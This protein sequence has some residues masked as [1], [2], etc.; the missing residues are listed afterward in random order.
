MKSA[1]TGVVK[2]HLVDI[3]AI[4]THG[5]FAEDEDSVIKRA[6]EAGVQKLVIMSMH[7]EGSKHTQRMCN[8]FKSYL[9][10]TTSQLYKVRI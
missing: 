4:P 6:K 5:K 10:F 7:V 2:Y 1:V 3:R 8:F 9:Y